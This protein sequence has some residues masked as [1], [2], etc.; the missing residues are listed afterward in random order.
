MVTV[1]ILFL[2]IPATVYEPF[3]AVKM[4]PNGVKLLCVETRRCGCGWFCLFEKHLREI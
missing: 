1:S 3:H 2:A 4:L